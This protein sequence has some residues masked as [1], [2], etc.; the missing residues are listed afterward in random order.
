MRLAAVII[1]NFRGFKTPTR[2]EFAGLTGIVGRND[3]GKSSILEA[4]DIF[5]DGGTCSIDPDD[6][7]KSADGGEVS[8]TCLFD[9]LPEQVV[10]D[11]TT[12]TTLQEEQLLN[13]A[14]LLEIKKTWDCSKAKVGKPSVCAMAIHSMMADGS[15]PL[16]LTR[17]KL[18]TACQ[19]AGVDMAGVNQNENP[20]M[21]QALRARLAAPAA[22]VPV[23]LEKEDAKAV[24]GAIQKYMPTFALFKSDRD[25]TDGDSEVQAPLKAAVKLAVGAAQD[26]LADVLRQVEQVTQDVATR[27]LRKL[28]EMSP[29]LAA[30]LKADFETPK[31]DSVFKATLRTDNEIP[32]NKRG[33]GVRRLILLNFFRAEAERLA[34]E[35]GRPIIYA[36]EE[37]ETSQHPNNQRMLM[38][39]LEELS[40]LANVQVI[41]TTHVP[42]LAGLI[43]TSSLRL[44]E[45]SGTGPT[46]RH[47]DDSI[48]GSIAT[49]LGIIADRRLEVLV[50]VEG[51]TDVRHLKAICKLHREQHPEL[52]CLT[53]DPR[54]AVIPLGGSTLLEWASQHYLR[55]VG[56]REFHVYDRWPIRDGVPEYQSACEDVNGRGAGFSACLTTKF[57][58]ENYLHS[59]AIHR[60]CGVRVTVADDN[61]VDEA[62]ATAGGVRKRDIKRR[63][64][65][66]MDAMTHAELVARDAAGE[67]LGWMRTIA[68]LLSPAPAEGR[69]PD[70]AAGV[71]P[72]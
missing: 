15:S 12:T 3:V 54:I 19:N 44:V 68:G 27:T 25:S 6:R 23:E 32:L 28:A 1:E 58:V 7:C 30:E 21:R 56:A 48:Y 22:A 42:A 20:P 31:W 59:D 57:E 49:T 55:K 24:W 43:P 46:V 36:I 11:T 4:L 10:I 17:A 41:V 33:S 18:R 14:G 39:A 72:R 26:Q 38:A 53:T 67:T 37:P 66:A 35:S 70:H 5:F 8:V 51:P 2:V 34:T 45:R 47:G 40:M 50:C 65:D 63:L 62:I 64:A 71:A 29:D 61:R 13:A 52:P 16:Y 9:E 60:T 69:A